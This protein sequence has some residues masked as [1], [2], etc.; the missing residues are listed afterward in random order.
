MGEKL[1]IEGRVLKTGKKLAFT[2]VDIK[3]ADKI[4]ATGR[5]TKAFPDK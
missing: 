3:V 2:D 4:I 1:A 5:H